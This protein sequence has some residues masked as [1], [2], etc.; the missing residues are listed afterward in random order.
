MLLSLVKAEDDVDV[1]CDQADEAIR[2]GKMTPSSRERHKGIIARAHDLR[3][4]M[5]K[6]LFCFKK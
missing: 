5:M 3:L 1:T 2:G 4:I 6:R